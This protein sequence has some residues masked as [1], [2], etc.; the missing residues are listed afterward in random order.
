ML[1][2]EQRSCF[3]FIEQVG[4]LI[5]VAGRKLIKN[6]SAQHAPGHFNVGSVAG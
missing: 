5:T 1:V 2:V 3:F 6:P 4:G